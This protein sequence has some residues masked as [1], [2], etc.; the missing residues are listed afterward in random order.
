M[1]PM[2]PPFYLNPDD[3]RLAATLTGAY[4]R[5]AVWYLLGVLLL[6]RL[7][8]EGIWQHPTP[9]YA[10]VMP[11]FRSLETP[12]AVLAIMTA[13]YIRWRTRYGPISAG[14]RWFFAI[15]CAS[16][17]LLMTLGFVQTAQGTT[18]A[19]ALWA[20]W[21]QIRW[22]GLAV[23]VFVLSLA[24]LAW[25]LERI[26]WFD[27]EPT[28]RSAGWIVVALVVFAF[29]FPAAIAMLR[30][31]VHGI[32]QA[33]ERHGLEYIGD[34]GI[35][36]SIRGLFHDFIKVHPYLSA[37]SRVHP[38]GPIA[39]LWAMSYVAGRQALGLSLATMAAGA[40]GIVPLYLW[41]KDLTSRRT[42]LTCCILY[43]LMPSIV[44][45]TATSLDIAFMPLTLTTLFLFSRAMN[46][47][48]IPSMGYAAAAG[49]MY[50]VL[51]LISF[52]LISLGAFFAFEGL[53]AMAKPETRRAV[54]RTALVM[55]TC[56]AALHAA[57]WA[58]SGFD[59][60]GAF[61]LASAQFNLDQTHLDLLAPRYP[62][63]AW[64]ILNPAC[65]FFFAGIPVSLLFLWRLTRPESGTKTLFIV[66][67][68]T[69]ATLAFLYLARGEGER[70]AMYLLPF[71]VLPAAHML[72][73][74]GR[75]A[76][77]ITPLLATAAFLAFQ[78]WFIE[79]C[80]HTYW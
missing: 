63:W 14:S 80:F 1:P 7:G 64:K 69:L 40:L 44:V 67:A 77:S 39:I 37:H 43:A 56:A 21:Q 12:A 26:G 25:A 75:T 59:M 54:F 42:A 35:G 19:G 13:V 46:R 20:D 4:V 49:T 17:F 79:S 16:L 78:C 34:I 6:W 36:G 11:A 47:P 23:A 48:S 3:D 38:P 50:A 32:A 66:F 27:A 10:L 29:V 41:A 52:S 76:R 68:F 15:W 31:G 70:S 57:V 61:K 24:C 9:F 74:I 5:T 65:W 73:Q 55:A 18:L 71:V 58:W 30:G 45:F 62:A 28:P 8:F 51:S 72:D 22:H 33:Y 53:A 2:P 60:I